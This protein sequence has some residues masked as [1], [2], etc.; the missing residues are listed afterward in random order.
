VVPTVAELGIGAVNEGVPAV[1]S[2]DQPNGPVAPDTMD[3][4]R[5]E[6]VE[7]PLQYEMEDGLTVSVANTF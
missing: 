3:F 1:G 6:S 5:T 7:A 4:I 2:V